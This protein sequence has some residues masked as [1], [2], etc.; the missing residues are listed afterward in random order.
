MLGGV[1]VALVC[2]YI[3]WPH[4]TIAPGRGRSGAAVFGAAWAAIP[5]YLQAKRGSHIVITTIMF[6]FIAA[7]LLNWLL[8]GPLKPAGSMEP[9]T[10]TFP[11]ATHLPSLQDDVLASARPCCSAAP[12]R[13]SRFFVAVAACVALWALIWRTRLGYEIRAFG[14]SEPAA[15]LCRN[16]PGQDHHGDDADLGRARRAAWRS[17]T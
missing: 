10:T 9:A 1:G 16:R 6:N 8:I 14:H 5:A 12:R 4:W 13:I 3:P 17:T 11:P 2:L 7:A 15:K